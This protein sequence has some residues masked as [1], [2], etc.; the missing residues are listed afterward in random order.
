VNIKDNVLHLYAPLERD[1]L[2]D[3]RMVQESGQVGL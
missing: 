1:P 3:F 2:P